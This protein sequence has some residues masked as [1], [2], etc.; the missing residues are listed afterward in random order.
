LSDED[1][2]CV[3]GVDYGGDLSL[4]AGRVEM[5]VHRTDLQA[6]ECSECQFLSEIRREMLSDP[7]RLAAKRER[8][9]HAHRECEAKR[10]LKLQPVSGRV[11]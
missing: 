11:Q 4:A 8:M 3:G 7:E 6:F 1:P 5:I 9:E 10:R 2:D